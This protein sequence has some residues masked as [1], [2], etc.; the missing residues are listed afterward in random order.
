MTNWKQR[1]LCTTKYGFVTK[2]DRAN[3]RLRVTS[4][5]LKG[6]QQMQNVNDVCVICQIRRALKKSKRYMEWVQQ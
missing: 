4:I 5:A 3:H 1:K 2:L 6:G